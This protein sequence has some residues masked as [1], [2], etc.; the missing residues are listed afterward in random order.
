MLRDA[1]AGIVLLA[2]SVGY[3]SVAQS[4]PTSILDTSVSSAAFPKLIG[5]AGALLSLALIGQSLAFRWLS[6]TS[7]FGQE[8][9]QHEDWGAHRSALGLLF[10]VSMF[11]LLL[12]FLGYPAAIASLI[13]AVSL[14]QG[15]PLS[16]VSFA[17]SIA[18]GFLFWLFFSVFVGLSLPPGIWRHL[19]ALS[20]TISA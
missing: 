1:A 17:V 11:V 16:W 7:A 15:Y 6:H 12:P 18:G 20:F 5:I 9:E 14:Y 3:Y 19:S 13:F 2:L 4:M 8:K 10:I